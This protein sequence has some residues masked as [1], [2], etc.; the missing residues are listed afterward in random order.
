M[1]FSLVRGTAVVS[2]NTLIIIRFP[3]IPIDAPL[4]S[5]RRSTIIYIIYATDLNKIK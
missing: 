5:M 4:T 2:M 3:V 1:T